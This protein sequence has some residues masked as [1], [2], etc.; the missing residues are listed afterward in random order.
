M[1]TTWRGKNDTD[2]GPRNSF[3]SISRAV[4]TP[5]NKERMRKILK[6]VL[7]VFGTLLAVDIVSFIIYVCINGLPHFLRSDAKWS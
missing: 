1:E 6:T 3:E 7:I 2:D 4:S 5:K